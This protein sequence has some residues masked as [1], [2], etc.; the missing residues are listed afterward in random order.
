MTGLY[1]LVTSPGLNVM[2]IQVIVLQVLIVQ[3]LIFT[4]ILNFNVMKIA[5]LVNTSVLLVITSKHF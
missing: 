5:F 1:P 4:S 2:K 3:V